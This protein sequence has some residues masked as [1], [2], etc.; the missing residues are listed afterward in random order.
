MDNDRNHQ[1]QPLVRALGQLQS[2]CGFLSAV[3]PC[4]TMYKGA[5]SK[6]P[7]LP[8]LKLRRSYLLQHTVITHQRRTTKCSHHFTETEIVCWDQVPTVILYC[9]CSSP[10]TAKDFY[11]SGKVTILLC[12][13]CYHIVID[14]K[15]YCLGRSYF[16]QHVCQLTLSE[17]MNQI[18]HGTFV[19]DLAGKMTIST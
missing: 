1:A 7:R 6:C 17:S 3:K 19:D 2:Q 14:C 18:H 9:V 16:T 12:I 8:C 4:R 13:Q 10:K 5:G 11:V 15:V